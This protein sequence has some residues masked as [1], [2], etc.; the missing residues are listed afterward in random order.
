MD[1]ESLLSRIDVKYE[2][3]LKKVQGKKKRDAGK[4]EM[5]AIADE[6]EVLKHMDEDQEPTMDLL[7]SKD[8]DIIF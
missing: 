2:C 1:L 7:S 6:E 3:R 5:Q 8:E 4:A